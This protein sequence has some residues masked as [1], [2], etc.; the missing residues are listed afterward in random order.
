M[1]YSRK[2]A[3]S[4]SD[5]RYQSA[6]TIFDEIKHGHTPSENLLSDLFPPDLVKIVK[7]DLELFF[8]NNSLPN[9][10]VRQHIDTAPTE[11]SDARSK[12]EKMP[13]FQ[14][15]HSALLT[16]RKPDEL[17]VKEFYGEY[18]D[19]AQLVF[20]MFR[21]YKM[22]RK[23]GLP[24]AAHLNRVGAIS[25]IIN[26]NDPGSKLYSAIAV[27]HD[28]IEDMLYKAVDEFGVHYGFDRYDEFIHKFIPEE[29]REGIAILTNTTI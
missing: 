3:Q 1:R 23:C 28:L 16:R 4:I 27:G 20:E 6:K 21:S 8:A 11:I 2:I 14:A 24:S 26:I 17:I 18:A 7:D 22:F 15:L 5:H 9:K 12:A 29:L 10:K 19:F 25:S 13:S